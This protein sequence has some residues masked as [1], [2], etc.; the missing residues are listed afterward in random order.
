M[1]CVDEG[2]NYL[3][4]H[5]LIMEAQKVLRAKFDSIIKPADLTNTLI[6]VKGSLDKLRKDGIIS[7]EH[8]KLLNPNP[9]SGKFDATLLTCLLQ[10]ICNLNPNDKVWGEKDNANIKGNTH[11]ENI[12]RIRNLRNKVR[13]NLF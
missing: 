2:Q 13:V 4:L 5:V 7:T 8:Y 1:A 6:R 10:N 3:R 12:Q 11:Q 9:D